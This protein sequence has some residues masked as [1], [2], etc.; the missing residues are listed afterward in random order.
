MAALYTTAD[1][2]LFP[3]TYEGFGYPVLE[4][5]LCGTPVV[6]S[7]AAS[8]PEV[9]GDGARLF[10]P[11]DIA[12]MVEAAAELL[13]EPEASTALVAAGHAN[14]ARFQRARW[15]AQHQALWRSLGCAGHGA[16]YSSS[17]AA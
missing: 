7:D 16:V 11:Y 6:C 12:G 17:R 3:S 9:A 8:L 2:L 1:L 10:A 15:F 13:E 4:A 5:Q 14:A